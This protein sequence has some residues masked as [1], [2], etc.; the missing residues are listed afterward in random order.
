VT[1]WFALVVRVP[2]AAAEIVFGWAWER[3]ITG[4]E[5]DAE[6]PGRVIVYAREPWDEALA[7][8]EI[9]ERLS[10]AGESAPPHVQAASFPEED[11][12]ANWMRSWRPTPLG[13]RL[14]V[15]P[16]W[17]TEP[18]PADRLVLRLD[19]GPAFG[20][21]THAT[22]ALAWELLEERLLEGPARA[23]NGAR[24]SRPSRPSRPQ[25]PSRLLEVGAGS[26]I[27]SLGAFLLCPGLRI[28]ATE[29]D[30]GAAR[31]F[32]G[33]VARAGAGGRVRPVRAR[34]VPV[35]GGFDLAVANLTALEH[36]GVAGD[37]RAALAPRARVV[38]AGMREEDPPARSWPD[39]G[40]RLEARVAREG[41]VGERWGR[42]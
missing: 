1:T 8:A 36:A 25:A 41:W 5:E 37:L 38:L 2:P 23:A 20:T 33:N 35:R 24:S 32:A 9:A 11:W 10:R 42:G 27:L 17:W 15:V 6:D 19:P 7:R 4:A 34:G 39:N 21:G 28:V 29:A 26:G 14:L 13:T 12:Q 31:A 3:D 30:P 22:T 16:S 40:F 18:L